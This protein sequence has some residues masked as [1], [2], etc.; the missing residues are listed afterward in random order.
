MLERLTDQARGVL[1]RAEEQARGFHHRSI[2][3]EHVLLGLTLVEGVAANALY[4]LG[5]SPEA[6]RA[7]VVQAIV[8]GPAGSWGGP[9]RVP[10]SQQAKKA[11][12]TSFR[13]AL[14]AGH[15]HIGTEH[16]LLGLLRAPEGDV[17]RVLRTIGIDG[18]RLYARVLSL[19]ERGPDY[20]VTRSPALLEA[21]RCAQAL[22][23]PTAVTTGHFLEA[24]LADEKSQAS[25]VL[26]ALGVGLDDVRRELANVPVATT[27]DAPPKPRTVEI[28]LGEAT[29]TVEDP[30]LAVALSAALEGFSPE[31]V[32]AALQ[33]AFGGVAPA[34]SPFT[35]RGGAPAPKGPR[36][37][38]QSPRDS[39]DAPPRRR[40]RS[41]PPR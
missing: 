10:F 7:K 27:S 17:P 30:D 36:R 38:G 18:D 11:L 8:P 14:A 35:S 19:M 33:K 13:E 9:Y 20:E 15:Q 34:D 40:R 16:L 21:A 41:L 39:G 6:V 26:A 29:T 5:A 25:A 24:L 3:P 32:K 31:Q 37:P 12:E 23:A 1:V 4:Q 2:R 22:A 28:R